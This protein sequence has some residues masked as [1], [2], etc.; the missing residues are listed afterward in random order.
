M[1]D[2]ID[3]NDMLPDDNEC[4]IIYTHTWFESWYKEGIFFDADGVD[5]FSGVTHWMRL[6]RPHAK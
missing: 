1:C 5:S 2:W 4:V 3:V 6:S